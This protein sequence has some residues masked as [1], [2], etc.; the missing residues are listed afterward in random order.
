[1]SFLRQER[2][3]NQARHSC[4]SN[5]AISIKII[6]E[7]YAILSKERRAAYEQECSCKKGSGLYR[8]TY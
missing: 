1:M 2:D 3:K 6:L 8:N 7:S 4:D 5:R